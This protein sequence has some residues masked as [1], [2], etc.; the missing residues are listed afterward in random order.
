MAELIVREGGERVAQPTT[1]AYVRCPQKV[2]SCARLIELTCT[3]SP[4]L[5]VTSQVESWRL[6]R[7]VTLVATC[8]NAVQ[9]NVD[10]GYMSVI[11][12]AYDTINL[13]GLGWGDNMGV[14]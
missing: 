7:R 13:F 6:N 11:K 4:I 10:C 12:G 5:R 1:V 3:A 2:G 14:L 8:Q 9:S